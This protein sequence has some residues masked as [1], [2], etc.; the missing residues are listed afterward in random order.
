[1]VK[2]IIRRILLLLFVLLL[3]NF[4][5]YAYAHYARWMQMAHNPLF[6]LDEVIEPVWPHYREY[7]LSSLTGDMG[8]TPGTRGLPLTKLLME[9]SRASLGLLG[10]AFGLSLALGLIVGLASVHTDPPRPFSWLVIATTMAITMPAFYLGATFIAA[11]VYYLLSSPGKNE[12]LLPLGGFGWDRHLVFP[13]LALMLR[14][15][16]QI[17]QTSATLLSGELTKV[18]T[19]VARSF[20][21][22]WRMIRSKVAF[23]NIAGNIALTIAGSLRLLVG[24]LIMV[25][26]LFSWPGLGKLLAA[27][28]Q[29]PNTVTISG[30]YLPEYYLHAP[31]V[32]GVVT[33]MTAIF[34]AADL[35]ASTINQALDPRLRIGEEARHA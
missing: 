26:W 21:F 11:S 3:V 31:T 7:L 30:V 4:L 15:T 20:G 19:I 9:A 32:A 8:D 10:S 18:Y 25:E 27:T 14:P 33:I 23:R 28:L 34:L 17:A 12:L 5:A 6:T 2:F 24:E 16:F 13:V 35:T 22:S 1:M 29:A